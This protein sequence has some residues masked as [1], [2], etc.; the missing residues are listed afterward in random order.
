MAW[1]KGMPDPSAGKWQVMS[2]AQGRRGTGSRHS[3]VGKEQPPP[4]RP[5]PLEELP[6]QV[7]EAYQD[8]CQD[9]DNLLE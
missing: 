9:Q 4:F 8:A 3:L 1:H 5:L 7:R 2:E 6:R